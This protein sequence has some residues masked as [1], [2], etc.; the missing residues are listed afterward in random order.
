MRKR[1]IDIENN[2]LIP[3]FAQSY[4]KERDDVIENY[5]KKEE[6]KALYKAIS[7]LSYMQQKLIYQVFF[8]N[9]SIKSLAKEYS[10][11]GKIIKKSLNKIYLQL[12]KSFFDEGG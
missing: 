5:I 4:D 9:R 10:I 7:K 8:E 1:F 6:I 3:S 12:R 2:Y 11:E